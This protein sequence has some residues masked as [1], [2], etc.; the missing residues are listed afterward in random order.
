VNSDWTESKISELLSTALFSPDEYRFSFGITPLQPDVFF[1]NHGNAEI[2][3]E[4]QR[5]L[6]EQPGDYVHTLERVSDWHVL[7]SAVAQWEPSASGEN[8][9]ALAATWEPDFVILSSKHLNPVLGGCVCFPSGWS[10]PEKAGKSLFVAHTPVP[11]LNDL[12]APKVGQFLSRLDTK[13]CFQRTNWGLTGSRALD[14][15][16]DRRIPAISITTDPA[17]VDLRIEWQALIGLADHLVLFGI[18]IFQ[19]P[20]SRVRATASLGK[21]LASNLASMPAAVAE[22]KRLARCRER[23]IQ[24]L[25]S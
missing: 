17:A 12:L 25:R 22:Y 20:L 4:K 2:L 3:R 10:L 1:A 13:R 15:H 24:Y 19:V 16:P 8:I 11:G 6:Q 21:L 14:Q 9:Q 23:L 5:L 7:A 18:R